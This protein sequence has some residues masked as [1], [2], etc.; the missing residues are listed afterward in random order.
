M[1]TFDKVDNYLKNKKS[2]EVSLIFLMIFVSIGFIVY[3]YVFPETEKALKKI[4]QSSKSMTARLAQEIAYQNSVTVNGNK[5]FFIQKLNKEIK[6]EKLLLEAKTFA[7]GYVD[8]KLKELS[9]L[10][11]NDENWASFLDSIAL[12]AKE[13]NI[14]IKLIENTFNEPNIHKIEQVLNVSIVFSGNFRNIIKFINTLEE[15]QLVV[16]LHDLELK[17]S[18]TING[19]LNIAVWGMKY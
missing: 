14:N 12:V 10:L 8:N 4:E 18:N 16:D 11:F 3:L 17:S 7:N 6:D 15:S 1:S 13:N 2:S 9:Y 5:N 19:N